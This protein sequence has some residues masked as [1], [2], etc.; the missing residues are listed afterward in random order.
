[1]APGQGKRGW[2]ASEAKKRLSASAKIPICIPNRVSYL[3][4]STVLCKTPEELPGGV[5]Q[6]TCKGADL[7]GLNPPGPRP[8]PRPPPQPPPP[9]GPPLRSPRALAAPYL[10][11]SAQGSPARSYALSSQA[12]S[13][14]PGAVQQNPGD[15]RPPNPSPLGQEKASCSGG[16][17]G[18]ECA[19]TGGHD[20]T[21]ERTAPGPGT[22][23]V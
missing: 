1:M 10:P 8:R 15:L 20:R 12:S 19:G 5:P 4:I 21:G 3:T 14:P 22:S 6:S 18:R 16:E 7:P 17:D 13:Q 11:G 23:R 9:P 2:K